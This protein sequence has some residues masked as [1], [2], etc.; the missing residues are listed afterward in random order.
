MEKRQYIDERIRLNELVVQNDKDIALEKKD[1]DK[2]LELKAQRSEFTKKLSEN[3]AKYIEANAPCKFDDEVEIVDFYNRILRG[4]AKA[5]HIL[6]DGNVYVSEYK[7][8]SN[9]KYL[10]RPHKSIEILKS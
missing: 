2:Q 9:T 7:A 3:K 1:S 4:K 8:G 5:F 10:S 6:E